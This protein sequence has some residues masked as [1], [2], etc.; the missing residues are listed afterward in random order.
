MG[1]QAVHFPDGR[2]Q[3]RISHA[4]VRVY[5]NQA[6]LVACRPFIAKLQEDASVTVVNAGSRRCGC[7]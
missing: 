5:C 7:A 6:T 3:P 2:E 1:R 4:R